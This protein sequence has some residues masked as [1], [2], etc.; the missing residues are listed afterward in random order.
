MRLYLRGRKVRLS[1]KQEKLLAR[2]L[3]ALVILL[4]IAT[5]TTVTVYNR[6]IGCDISG[7]G[8][9][10]YRYILVGNSKLIES[11]THLLD[12]FSEAAVGVL[13]N[14]SVYILIEI[15]SFVSKV[16]SARYY[17]VTKV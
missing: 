13:G 3:M 16:F 15:E 17:K 14:L 9:T 2:R 10:A 11:S 4:A 12:L 1:R 6:Y 8:I 5:L 7:V